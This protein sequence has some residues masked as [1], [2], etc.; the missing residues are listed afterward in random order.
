[1]ANILSKFY[2]KTK[3]LSI[4]EY[5]ENG[6]FEGLEKALHKMKPQE[7]LDEVISSNL[8]GRGGATF[9]TG[10][11]WQFTAN[12]SNETKYIIC[13]ADEGEPGTFKDKVLLEGCP[14]LLIEGMIIAAYAVGGTKGYIYI[15]GEYPKSKEML[16]NAI[17]VLKD[18][19]YLGD[20]ILDT[21]FSFDIEVRSGYGAYICGEETAL[22]ESIEGNPGR[23]RTKPPYPPN[24][25]LWG[26]PT[27]VNNVETLANIPI[28][29]SMGAEKFKEYGTASSSG[30]KLI[31]VSGSVVNKGVFEV[32]F[33]VTLKDIVYETCGGLTE[34]SKFKFLQLGGSAGACLP[35]NLLDTKLDFDDLR[36]RNIS[37]GSG[38]ILVADD[39]TCLLGFIKATA[40]F[41]EH[42]SC[43]KCTPCREGN[44]HV[45]KL[46]DKIVNGVATVED[47]E[48]LKD[49]ALTMKEMSLCGLGQAAPTALL[50]TLNYFEGEY[51]E[52]I[53]GYCR[54]GVCF[55][56]GGEV[57]NE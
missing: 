48:I 37:L 22:I 8:K 41:F 20:K 36:S 34:N 25:G 32:E 3:P 52:H 40:E 24:K 14:F 5:K 39:T 53:K 12:E 19:G 43:G 47:L 33:G 23:A 4:K 16:R 18:E 11:K 38:A 54:T 17:G 30:T 50:T 27:L 2:V 9:P 35:E 10:L 21:D 49:V 26:K 56:K 44:K 28:I 7:I 55:M 15:R 51:N 42:E 1:M 57:V 29:L 31:S 46:L 45:T 13:N 6:G